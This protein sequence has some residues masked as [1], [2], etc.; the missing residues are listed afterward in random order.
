MRVQ[1]QGF[2]KTW[3]KVKSSGPLIDNFIAS[4]QLLLI[5]VI[6]CELVLRLNKF[7][8]RYTNESLQEILYQYRPSILVLYFNRILRTYSLDRLIMAG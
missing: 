3:H 1:T 5:I 8:K 4:V 7:Y 6:L 2:H